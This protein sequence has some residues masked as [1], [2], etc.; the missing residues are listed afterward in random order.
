M[1]SVAMVKLQ[2]LSAKGGD[3]FWSS[4]RS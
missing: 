2:K 3:I 4:F 1:H